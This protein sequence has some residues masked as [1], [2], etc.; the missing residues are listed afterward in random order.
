MS[1][2]AP[3]IYPLEVKRGKITLRTN[4]ETDAFELPK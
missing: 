3:K 2:T 1:I 4:S